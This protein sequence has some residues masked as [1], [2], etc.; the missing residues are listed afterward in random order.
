MTFAWNGM[1]EA[2]Y[3]LTRRTPAF[4]RMIRHAGVLPNISHLLAERLTADGEISYSLLDSPL[5]ELTPS[6]PNTPSVH[7]PTRHLSPLLPVVNSAISSLVAERSLTPTLSEH[8]GVSNA[9]PSVIGLPTMTE[10]VETY[11]EDLLTQE[12][13]P[14]LLDEDI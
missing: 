11:M 13:C 7:S 6:A 3:L 1:R 4:R 12:F 9:T 8:I 14:V 2:D 10:L 5:P